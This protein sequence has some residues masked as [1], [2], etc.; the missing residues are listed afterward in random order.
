MYIRCPTFSPTELAENFRTSPFIFLQELPMLRANMPVKTTF[1]VEV[2][3]MIQLVGLED[4]L[5]DRS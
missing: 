5:I 2:I 4:I 1:P 3:L